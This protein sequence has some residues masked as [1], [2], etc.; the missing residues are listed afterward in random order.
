MLC[1]WEGNRR[2]GVAL[3]MRHRLSSIST[4]GLNG[5]R[6]GDEHPAYTPLE[7]CAFSLQQSGTLY[8]YEDSK[9]IWYE[10]D[11]CL[12]WI[13]KNRWWINNET[14]NKGNDY[15]E[16]VQYRQDLFIITHY[17]KW[18]HFASYTRCSENHNN[19]SAENPK[20][21]GL[22]FDTLYWRHLAA[23]RKIWT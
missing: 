12:F 5:L 1:G 11:S 4:N 23:Y 21:H 22:K 3:A 16:S 2:S 18:K 13:W 14:R 9:S 7:Y 10:V 20:I 6:K 8:V 15:L 17:H 19:T